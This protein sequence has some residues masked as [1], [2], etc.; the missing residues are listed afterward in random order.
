MGADGHCRHRHSAH[1]R[2]TELLALLQLPHGPCRS[3]DG[4]DRGRHPEEHQRLTNRQGPVHF[5]LSD[6]VFDIEAVDEYQ[7]DLQHDRPSHP[8]QAPLQRDVFLPAALF[9]LFLI[10]AFSFSLPR[11]PQPD[12]MIETLSVHSD[13]LLLYQMPVFFARHK[14]GKVSKF[15]DR[16]LS[17]LFRRERSAFWNGT[18]PGAIGWRGGHRPPISHGKGDPVWT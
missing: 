10:H 3:Q 9:S 16:S 13:S 4:G 17:S 7:E 2:Q 6:I 11:A 5:C 14:S 12:K 1:Q 18:G 15:K 8:K